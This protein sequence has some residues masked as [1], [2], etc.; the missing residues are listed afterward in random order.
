MGMFERYGLYWG[1]THHNTYMGYRQVPPLEDVLRFASTYL[2]FYTGAYYT[3]VFANAPVKPE[4]QGGAGKTKEGHPGEQADFGFWRGIGLEGHKEPDKMAEEWKEFQEV[5]IRW[6]RPGSFVAFPG[7][8]WQ[9]NGRW[10]DHNV[11][12]LEEGQPISDAQTVAELYAFLKNRNAIAIPHHTGYQVGLRAPTWAAC[13]E[14]L[15]PFQ[16]I[17]SIHGCSETDEEWVGLRNNTHMGPGFTGGTW[18]DALNAGLHTGCICSTDN[19]SN[20]PG[21]WNQ[22]IAA[23]LAKD[24][25][26]ESLFEAFRAR[27]VYGVTGDRIELDFT[28]NGQDMGSILGYSPKR[29][30]AV[31]VRGCEAIDR[32]E[33][34][35]ND[36]VI[37]T[38][39]HQGTWQMPKPGIRTKFKFRVEMGW[40]SRPGEIPMEDHDWN[41]RV[42]V[43]GGRILGWSPCWIARGQS[44]PEIRENEATF[45]IRTCQ[46][47]ERLG[48]YTANVFEFE[49]DPAAELGIFM[50]DQEVSDTV[51]G[52]AGKNRLIWFRD[53]CI[54]RIERL[55][56]I[57][58]ETARRGDCYYHN[59]WKGKIHKV[60]PEAAYCAKFEIDDDEPLS[61]EFHY[62]IRVE[63]RNGQRAW[64]SPIWFAGKDD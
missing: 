2:D 32:I 41:G 12:Y 61:R 39:C 48:R 10:G 26:R 40:G 54:G 14:T 34:L 57:T 62:R 46:I 15:T 50:D 23:C 6:N 9:G 38:H 33:I 56:G 58:P 8:E 44:A 43:S 28:A 22:G 11:V 3:P 49:A 59:S 24:L 20:M 36:Q 17:Y 29:K 64:S 47:H 30:I 18:Q 52:F 63:Q 1:D 27:R 16:E 4:F 53:D 60:I 45:R 37:A 35:R 19:W 25:S 7:Y 21:Q 51:K 55:T 31:S 42:R 5:T 13:D